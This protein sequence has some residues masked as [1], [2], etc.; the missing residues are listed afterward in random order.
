MEERVVEEP[1]LGER[2]ERRR[3]RGSA[4]GVELPYEPPSGGVEGQRPGALRFEPLAVLCGA[5]AL[6]LRGPADTAGV[7]ER[8]VVIAFDDRPVAGIDD[9]HRALTHER[10]G[11]PTAIT[12]IRRAEKLTLSVIPAEADS[13][14]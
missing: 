6:P 5:A 11:A 7:R 10:V 9:L 8:D 13:A 2:D 14:A 3:G 4:R 1:V 12:V